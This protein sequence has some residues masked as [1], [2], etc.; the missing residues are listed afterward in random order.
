MANPRGRPNL[1]SLDE[2]DVALVV[3]KS[4][5]LTHVTDDVLAKEEQL[6]V[7]ARLR[8]MAEQDRSYVAARQFARDERDLQDLIRAERAKRREE[9]LNSV[10]EQV[11]V[12][13]ASIRAMPNLLQRRVREA[14]D[15][16]DAP[17]LH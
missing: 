4:L 1:K 17:S 14:L 9:S 15:S 3:E 2:S 8:A 13:V 6:E 10:D 5:A 16:E 11:S 7:T 12:L